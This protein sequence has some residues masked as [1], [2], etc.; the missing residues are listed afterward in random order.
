MD[1][2][3]ASYDSIKSIYIAGGKEGEVMARIAKELF[4]KLNKNKKQDTNL[5]YEFFEVKTRRCIT[6]YCI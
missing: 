2:Q 5:F 6:H 1:E 3:T 4:Y